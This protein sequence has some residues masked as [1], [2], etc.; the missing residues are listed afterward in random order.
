[1]GPLVDFPWLSQFFEFAL[2][3][4]VVE[5]NGF[6]EIIPMVLLCKERESS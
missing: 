5:R 2:T 3:F 1:M 4:L 6:S